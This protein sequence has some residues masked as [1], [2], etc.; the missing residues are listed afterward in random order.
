MEYGVCD[1]RG[2]IQNHRARRISYIYK[3]TIMDMTNPFLSP[4]FQR[5]A[6]G[7]Q[8]IPRISRCLSY[9]E[10]S[11]VF[12]FFFFFLMGAYLWKGDPGKQ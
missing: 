10:L 9:M 7:F 4:G 5:R 12:F 2:F 6:K 11:E 8:E 3:C 1:K